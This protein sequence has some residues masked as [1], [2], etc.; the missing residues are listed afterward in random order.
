MAVCI[1]AACCLLWIIRY[2][3]GVRISLWL[4]AFHPFAH[5]PRS[6]IAGN[7]VP[8]FLRQHHIVCPSSFA[9]YILATNHNLLTRLV[10]TCRPPAAFVRGARVL[11]A[12]PRFFPAI[13]LFPT[14]AL[15][16]IAAGQS[17]GSPTPLPQV[18]TLQTR[19]APG[20]A[21]CV[22]IGSW[23]SVRHRGNGDGARTSENTGKFP[24]IFNVAFF[25]VGWSLVCC[26]SLPVRQSS[27]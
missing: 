13:P 2:E 8:N 27:C 4:S 5:I 9:I 20:A 14:W 7:S 6:G 24:I 22:G 18:R 19:S 16:W 12:S 21:G 11:T 25:L 17:S 23:A 15:E 3:H 10:F 26:K 1:A